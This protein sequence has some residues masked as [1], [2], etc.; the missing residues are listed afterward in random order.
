MPV[1]NSDYTYFNYRG[2]PTRIAIIGVV[3]D[4][5]WLSHTEPPRLSLINGYYTTM[6]HLVKPHASDPLPV[7]TISKFQKKTITLIDAF[8]AIDPTDTDNT[9]PVDSLC[10][11]LGL[12]H[13]S[14][15]N[16]LITAMLSGADFSIGTYYHNSLLG[17]PWIH[18]S[19]SYKNYTG[20]KLP[21]TETY[22][23]MP[24][25]FYQGRCLHIAVAICYLTL[26]LRTDKQLC[27]QEAKIASPRLRRNLKRIKKVEIQN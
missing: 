7:H 13:D 19:A 1:D 27:H 5:S 11:Y 2:V 9:G 16:A 14:P 26:C 25:V 12:P 24:I 17:I 10:N 18:V 23:D 22:G 8:K 15:V 4:V 6:K 21:W 20:Y 3:H